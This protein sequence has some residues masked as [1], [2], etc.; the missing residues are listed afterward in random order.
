MNN[1]FMK[2][3]LFHMFS[4]VT[5]VLLFNCYCKLYELSNIFKQIPSNHINY[6]LDLASFIVINCIKVLSIFHFEL[7]L[8]ICF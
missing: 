7:D 3:N 8:F 1:M 2:K 6:M 4:I 5:M